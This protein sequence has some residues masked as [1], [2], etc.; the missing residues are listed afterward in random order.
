MKKSRPE[1]RVATHAEELNR[2]AGKILVKRITESLRTKEH[3]SMALSGGS[4]PKGLYT[5]LATET[6]WREQIVWERIHFFWG[7]ERHVPPHNPESN[8]R[9]SY[10]ALLSKVP[11]PPANIHRIPAERADA[12]RSAQEYEQELIR[13]FN[14]EPGQLPRFDCMLQGMGPDG[15]TASLFPGTKALQERVRLVVANWVER[16]RTYRITMT[17]PVLNHS[18]FVF[19]L[20]SGEEKAE[21]LRKVLAEEG[22]SERLPAQLIQPTHGRLLWLVDRAAAKRLPPRAIENGTSCGC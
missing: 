12:N 1:I 15:H 19:F 21:T 14:L 3:F 7:D 18:D 16:L 8:Y 6:S 17:L 9:M 13:F 22:Q 20:V 5:L 4:T 11:L 2:L 10:E